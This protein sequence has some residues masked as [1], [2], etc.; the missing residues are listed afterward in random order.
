MSDTVRIAAFGGSLRADSLNTRLLAN[1]VRLAEPLC[2]I[3]R[4]EIRDLPL[5]DQ[6]L[7]PG[8]GGSGGPEPV[9]RFR[10]TIR[11]AD[12]VLIVSPEYSWSVPGPIKNA[13]DW[14]SRP[15]FDTP[16]TG[17][18]VLLAGASPGPAGTGRAQLHLRQIL[19]S[20]RALAQV[21]DLQV[22]FA[23]SKIGADGGLDDEVEAR[24]AALLADLMDDARAARTADSVARYRVPPTPA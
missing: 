1:A 23:G 8:M 21:E 22:P 16:L 13:L 7:D 24:L 19:H 15:A 18:P 11:A 17:K 5:Y 6:D 12:G 10:E 20:M 4:L 14:V 9:T 3:E 2:G